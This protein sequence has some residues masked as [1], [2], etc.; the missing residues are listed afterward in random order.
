MTNESSFTAH[1]I[2]RSRGILGPLAWG[3][4]GLLQ[5]V[6]GSIN[7]VT[8]YHCLPPPP[9]TFYLLISGGALRAFVLLC[10]VGI[11]WFVIFFYL[12]PTYI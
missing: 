2:G 1:S 7:W 6:G 10:L 12:T 9:N 5:S 8:G 4:P 11:V 3:L